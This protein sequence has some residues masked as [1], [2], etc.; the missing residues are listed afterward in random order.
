MAASKFKADM[1]QKLIDSMKNGYSFEASCVSIGIHRSTG[2]EWDTMHPTWNEAHKTGMDYRLRFWERMALNTAMG[3]LPQETIEAHEEGTAVTTVTK[4]SST[5]KGTNP[6]MII[7]M[8]K[9]AFR[10]MYSERLEF[11]EIDPDEG[12]DDEQLLKDTAKILKA[13]RQALKA[14]K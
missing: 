11:K 6:T 13:K 2:Y 10:D 3:I 7:F 9:T 14:V 5:P 4:D 12:K 8:L 1:P